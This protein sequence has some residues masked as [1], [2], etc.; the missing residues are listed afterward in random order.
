[1]WNSLRLTTK[2]STWTPLLYL[3]WTRIERSH[4]TTCFSRPGWA[5]EW[6][7]HTNYHS[8]Q[9]PNKWTNINRYKE[10]RIESNWSHHSIH[11]WFQT[12][13]LSS[14]CHNQFRNHPSHKREHQANFHQQTKRSAI[15]NR[16]WAASHQSC[17]DLL[18]S[19]F[20][21][22]HH[23]WLHQCHCTAYKASATQHSALQ[24]QRTHPPNL[25]SNS[26]KNQLTQIHSFVLSPTKTSSNKA[27]QNGL[28][29]YPNKELF[30][31]TQTCSLNMT[32]QSCW[33]KKLMNWQNKPRPLPSQIQN[34]EQSTSPTP[35]CCLIWHSLGWQCILNDTNT[36]TPNNH[37]TWT[38][39][40]TNGHASQ[41][42]KK[43]RTQDL[44]QSSS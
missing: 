36:T 25:V 6:T 44:S 22:V 5:S 30:S 4:T 35:M 24:K 21:T 1:M 28:K 32:P 39:L 8:H 29:R 33:M 2:H 16:R 37:S 20:T 17:F 42:K 40:P 14:H 41:T 38:H 12:R 18:R 13:R 11:W 26:K 34:K 3:I 23:H 9:L 15:S 43:P 27:Q 31:K 7:L 10:W 19:K